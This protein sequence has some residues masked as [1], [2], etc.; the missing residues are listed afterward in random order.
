MQIGSVYEEYIICMPLLRNN[1]DLKG[2]WVTKYNLIFISDV[3]E[4]MLL[5]FHAKMIKAERYIGIYLQWIAILRAILR[6][7]NKEDNPK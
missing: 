3:K 2:W 1:I 5:Y 4:I 6:G 7:I